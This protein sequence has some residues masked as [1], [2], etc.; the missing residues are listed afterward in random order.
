[1]SN[2]TKKTSVDRKIGNSDKSLIIYTHNDG[3]K[4]GAIIN[5]TFIKN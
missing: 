1:M 4:K 2:E 3:F 5:G